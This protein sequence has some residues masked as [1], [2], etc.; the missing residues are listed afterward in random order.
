MLFRSDAF[1]IVGLGD[2]VVEAF[3]NDGIIKHP[4]DIFTLEERN[5]GVGDDLFAF[6]DEGLHLERR[7]GWGKLSV[8]NLFAAIRARQTISLPRFIYAL[9]IPQVGS[10]TALLLAQNYG[11]F[12]ALQH[13]MMLRETAKLVAIDGIGGEMGNDIVEFFNEQHNINEIDKLRQYIKVENYVDERRNDSA[14]SG[15][16]VVF[17]GTLE[18]MTR[19]EAKALAQKFGAKVAGSVSSHTDYVVVGT[20]AGSKARKAVELGIKTLSETEFITITES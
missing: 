18:K 7:A 16:T 12:D 10:A 13:D 17:T 20:D 9:G 19:A 4:A 2:K 6:G 1:D 15:K 8:D 5:G 11:T 14:L 3:Y